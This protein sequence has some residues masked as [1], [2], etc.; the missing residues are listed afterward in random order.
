MCVICVLCLIVVALPPGK[1]PFA[2]KVNKKIKKVSTNKHC[3][4][5]GSQNKNKK[6]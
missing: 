5:S 2:V 3:V 1:N 4:L 6:L